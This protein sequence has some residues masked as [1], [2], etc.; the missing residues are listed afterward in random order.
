LHMADVGGSPSDL[1]APLYLATQEV[2]E[3]SNSS[4]NNGYY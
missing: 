2:R 1:C 3:K 4:S